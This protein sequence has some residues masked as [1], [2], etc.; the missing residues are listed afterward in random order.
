MSCD[1]GVTVTDGCID[2]NL[3][4]FRATFPLLNDT[5]YPD[6]AVQAYWCI[7]STY[8]SS[9]V[10]SAIALNQQFMLLNYMTAHLIAYNDLVVSGAVSVADGGQGFGV[11][12]LVT[13]AQEDSVSFKI[14]PPPVQNDYFAW[15]TTLTPYGKQ[16]YSLLKIVSAGGIYLGGSNGLQ[17]LNGVRNGWP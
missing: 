12:N 6:A 11:A 10:T 3:V 8:M 16:F 17:S 2:L 4:F 5:D 14:L 1:L 7:A 9:T 13:D 15:F